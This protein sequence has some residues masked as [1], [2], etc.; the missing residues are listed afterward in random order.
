MRYC[1]A[2]KSAMKSWKMPIQPRSRGRVSGGP[3]IVGSDAQNAWISSL[4]GIIGQIPGFSQAA[5]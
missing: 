4:L 2:N 1:P 3:R 5:E